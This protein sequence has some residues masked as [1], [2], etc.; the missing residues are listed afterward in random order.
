MSILAKGEIVKDIDY[1][2]GLDNKMLKKPTNS[3]Y[4][5]IIDVKKYREFV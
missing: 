4:H 5:N 3:S 2:N 1:G